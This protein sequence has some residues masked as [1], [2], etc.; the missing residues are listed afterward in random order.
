MDD[1]CGYRTCLNSICVA[2]NCH[3]GIRN[4][5]ESD[6][7]C[8][9]N[10]NF[11]PRCGTGRHCTLKL[12]CAD[13][14]CS[15]QMCAAPACNDQLQNGLES[16]IDCGGPC[17]PCGLGLGC[18]TG[19]DCA[20]T[21]C[22]GSRCVP[23]YCSDGKKDQDETDLDC[24]GACGNCP[25]GAHCNVASDCAGRFCMLGACAPAHCGNQIKDGDET[26]VDC[27]GMRCSPC[28]DG[29]KCLSPADCRFGLQCGKAG[30]CGP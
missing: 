12:D 29:A 3:D 10:N 24:G 16:D 20:T 4:E 2:P 26:D 5:G 11:C 15:G 14:V 1:D 19:A 22:L 30:V 7:D 9:G 18:R 6:V 28:G 13:K 8:G 17:A 21:T 27:G 25:E 23:L